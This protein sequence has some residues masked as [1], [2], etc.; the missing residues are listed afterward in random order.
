MRRLG[1]RQLPCFILALA[2][3]VACSPTTHPF[4]PSPDPEKML[5]YEGLP[6][7]GY[8]PE[9]LA[10]ESRKPTITR[11]EFL[12]YRDPLPLDQADAKALGSI[13][14]NADLFQPFVAEMKCGGFHPD[15]AIA[16]TSDGE[17]T[18]YLI[19]FGCGEAGVIRAGQPMAR[20][21]L[22]HDARHSPLRTI[23]GHYRK[24][25]PVPLIGP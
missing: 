1:R 14:A 11:G 19:C 16:V 9:R 6:H 18:T 23:L 12:F 15:Y 10:E 7:Q 17:E 20:Y 5:L 8:E 4:L 13:L 2:L 21:V 22:G 3:I 24:N 25:R